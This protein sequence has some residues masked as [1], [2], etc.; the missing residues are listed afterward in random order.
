MTAFGAWRWDLRLWRAV[1]GEA[2]A[3]SRQSRHQERRAGHANAGVA[4]FR[5]CEPGVVYRFREVRTVRDP[6]IRFVRVAHYRRVDPVE[7]LVEIENVESAPNQIAQTTVRNA[8][9]P[10]SLD[11]VLGDSDTRNQAMKDILGVTA[12]RA[13]VL[14]ELVELKNMELP[15]TME[16]AMAREAKAE[17]DSRAKTIAAVGDALSAG[18]LAELADLIVGCPF[19]CSRAT[20][21]SWLRSP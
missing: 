18:R 12:T 3:G 8:L 15:P 21:S 16:Q 14:V 20:F 7:S 9:G 11:Q 5:Q 13:G 17:R 10:S 1:A 19:V 2:E 6:G 4:I